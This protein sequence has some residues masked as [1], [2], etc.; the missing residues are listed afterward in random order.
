LEFKTGAH[1]HVRALTLLLPPPAGDMPA[2]PNIAS[3]PC[4]AVLVAALAAVFRVD[5]RPIGSHTGTAAAPLAG[6]DMSEGG[7]KPLPT[8]ACHRSP[9]RRAGAPAAPRL[10]GFVRVSLGGGGCE[11]ASTPGHMCAQAWARGMLGTA[12]VWRTLSTAR[13]FCQCARTT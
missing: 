8:P 11:R 7:R 6:D 13:A 9:R 5:A 4:S 2:R 10:L 12:P 1:P 3:D